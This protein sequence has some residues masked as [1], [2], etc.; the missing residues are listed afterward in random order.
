MV[1][2]ETVGWCLAALVAGLVYEFVAAYG[3]A[4]AREPEA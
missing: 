2:I 1:T 3:E 4:L